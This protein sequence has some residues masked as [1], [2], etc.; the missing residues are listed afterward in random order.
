MKVKRFDILR[1]QWPSGKVPGNLDR[2]AR[3]WNGGVLRQ[4]NAEDTV[5]EL[6]GA[7][8]RQHLR[9]PALRGAATALIGQLQDFL[10]TNR[11]RW[12]ELVLELVAAGHGDRILL[13]GNSIGVA[14]GL[15]EYNLPY[16]HVLATFVPFLKARGLA[17]D[18]ARRI[19][20]DNPRTLL[21]VR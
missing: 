6:V 14:K 20:V 15:P 2:F 3:A 11:R 19:L 1:G 13:S 4:Y 7:D 8:L 18:D 17:D 16:S 5:D 12:Q 9:E 21:A 10:H